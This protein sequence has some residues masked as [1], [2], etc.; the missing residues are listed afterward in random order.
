MARRRPL[1]ANAKPPTVERTSRT[2]SAPLAV[3]A[4]A[5][6]PADQASAPFGPAATWSIQRRLP[7]V[8]ITLR[9]PS[10]SVATTLPSSPPVTMRSA[11]ALEQRTAPPCAATVRGSPARGTSMSA[12]SPSTRTAVSPRKCAPTMPAPALTG[13]VRSTTEGMSLRASVTAS[14]TAPSRTLRALRRSSSSPREHTRLSRHAARKSFPDPLLRQLAADED[15]AAF[16]FLTVVPGALV[17]AVE[18]HVH[19]LEHEARGVV[20]ERQDALA[21]QDARPLL[22]HEILHPGEELVGVERLVGLERHRMHLLVVIVLQAA[23]VVVV[24]MAV[25]VLM[26]MMVIMVVMR[27]RIMSVAQELRLDLQDAVKIEGV[28]P[29]HLR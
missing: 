19:T 10:A 4:N 24:V 12:C 21:A 29:E 25:A 11:S 8:A 13:R 28:A 6:L 18:D 22:L 7:S 26:I 9:S 14:Q 1:G 27:V 17:V 23:A 2:C 3:R 16:A 5:S 15:D 20:L